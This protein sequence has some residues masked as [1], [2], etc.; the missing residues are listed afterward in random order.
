MWVKE[1]KIL[2]FLPFVAQKYFFISPNTPVYIQIPNVLDSLSKMEETVG[3]GAQE[4]DG[5]NR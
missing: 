4:R 3:Q 2:A 5:E 1:S